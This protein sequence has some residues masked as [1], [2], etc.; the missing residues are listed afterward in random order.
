MFL[1]NSKKSHIAGSNG[2]F[3]PLDHILLLETV[4]ALPAPLATETVRSIRQ[5]NRQKN[6]MHKTI[7]SIVLTTPYVY[8]CKKVDNSL[9]NTR[10]IMPVA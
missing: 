6:K 10:T 8:N 4:N 9:N 2:T 7:P 1:R 3:N 5:F